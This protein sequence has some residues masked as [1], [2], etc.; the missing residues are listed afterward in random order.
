MATLTTGLIG[1]LILGSSAMTLVSSLGT[2]VLVGTITKTTNS[3]TSMIG[4]LVQNNKPG[5]NDVTEFLS[6]IDLEFT[7]GIIE[8]VVKEQEGKSLNDSIKKALIGVNSILE[9]IHT[10]L[11]TIKQAIDQHSSKYFNSWRSF[12]W[13]GNVTT[14]K[15]HN[16]I[17]QHRYSMLFE[18]LKI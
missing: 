2:D 6:S 14:L 3:I 7:I 1:N 11:D 4:Y 16:E 5:I 12:S 8:Q 18:L 15:K 17:L 13:N 9:L 10:E